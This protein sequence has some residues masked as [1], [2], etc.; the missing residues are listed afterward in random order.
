MT[1]YLIDYFKPGDM[2]YCVSP[3]DSPLERGRAYRVW[4]LGNGI[5]KE[6]P[7][8]LLLEGL[9]GPGDR[10]GYRPDRFIRAEA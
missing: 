10:V 6:A 3:D 4:K 5:G 7:Y 1:N 2:V 8:T 9:H